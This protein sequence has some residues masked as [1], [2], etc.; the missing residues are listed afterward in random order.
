[1]VLFISCDKDKDDDNIQF[2]VGHWHVF[3]FQ[4]DPNSPVEDSLLA[5]KAIKKLN[6]VG[7]DSIEYTFGSDGE[8]YAKHGLQFVSV[9]P[10]ET[11]VEFGCP[12][13]FDIG[14]GTFDFDNN[15]LTLNYDQGNLRI[16]GSMEGDYLT[17]KVINIII[18]DKEV[19]GKLFFM[20]ETGE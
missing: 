12:S 19:S 17:T 4:P 14:T 18:N 5:K 11:D 8:F 3:D 16:E 15:L 20:R 7:C 6:E 10:S 1:M 2:L 9:T 13:Q